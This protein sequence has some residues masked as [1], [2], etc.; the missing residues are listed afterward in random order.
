MEL[1]DRIKNLQDDS[2][3]FVIGLLPNL[4]HYQQARKVLEESTELANDA[5]DEVE[6]ADVLI[7]LLVAAKLKGINTDKLLQVAETKM[8][9]NKTRKWGEA[10]ANGLKKHI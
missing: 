9:L 1:T 3:Q 2:Y 4:T 5:D 10:D 7:S 6:Y 8:A